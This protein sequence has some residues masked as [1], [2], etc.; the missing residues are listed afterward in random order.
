MGGKRKHQV[1][2]EKAN[3][4]SKGKGKSYQKKQTDN[5]D[6]EDALKNKSVVYVIVLVALG[7]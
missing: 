3:S 2:E 6:G 1:A 5:E 4:H 7:K